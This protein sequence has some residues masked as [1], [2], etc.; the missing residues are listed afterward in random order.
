[1]IRN[2]FGWLGPILLIGLITLVAITSSISAEITLPIINS[3]FFIG[4]I[5]I[6]IGAGLLANLFS[7]GKKNFLTYAQT[8]VHI[9]LAIG[10]I[11]VWLNQ[12]R[13]QSGYL[14][15][16]AS[17]SAKNYYLNKNLKTIDELPIALRIDSITDKY[18]KGFNPAPIAWL[19]YNNTQKRLTFNHPF[20]FQGIQLLLANLVDPGFP[21]A[22]EITIN[23]QPYN[24]LHNQKLRLANGTEI[25]SNAF[26]PESKSI[27]LMVMNRQEWLGLGDTL[28]LGSSVI[29][30]E[31]VDFSKHHGAILLVKD[32]SLRFIIYLGFGLML[33]G[34]IP[35]L[36]KKR[37]L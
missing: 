21:H 1:L 20:Y 32:I 19:H 8:I 13:S 29:V 24:L 35:M 28:R 7:F 14:F 37:D 10:L 31:S 9:G 5:I 11:G 25:W 2:W 22:Y 17:G 34:L 4:T 3:V 12:T 36:F 33:I 18:Q 15:L 23:D 16:E 30:L 27:G 6:V 26:D